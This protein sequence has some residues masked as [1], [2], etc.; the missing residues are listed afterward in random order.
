MLGERYLLATG[1][2]WDI[3]EFRSA[4]ISAGYQVAIRYHYITEYLR[5]IRYY[6]TT[7]YLLT[8]EYP[9]G[10]RYLAS[11]GYPSSDV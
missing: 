8:T 5:D 9:L 2:P 3:A 10:I 6:R 1:Y 7:G 4:W 11:T